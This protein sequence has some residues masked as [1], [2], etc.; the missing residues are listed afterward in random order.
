MGLTY[1]QLKQ[2]ILD[3]TEND[4]VEFTT[5]TG[6]GIAP[7]DLCIQLAEQRLVREA[8]I[9]AYRKTI[10]ITLGAG[11]MFYDMPQDLFVTRY[12]KIKTGEFL[13]EKDHTFIREF[14]QNSA[15]TGK[16]LYYAPYGEGT[17]S[18]SDRGMQ[19][20]FSHK[21]DLAYPLEVGYTIMPTGL[22]TGNANSYLGDYAPDVI[23]YGALIEAAQY[24]K[25]TPEILDR[26]R[27]LYDRAL[28]TFLVFEQGRVRSDENVKGE[29][30]TRG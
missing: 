30:G 5:A 24:M 28:Q 21:T 4:A 8:D 18:A 12:I 19:W 11:N 27:G 25:E 16:P 1:V 17:Y 13:M 20:I 15:T 23:L 3:W 29:I 6:S 9:T 10:D 2:A 7:V 14:T 22:G 26:Y